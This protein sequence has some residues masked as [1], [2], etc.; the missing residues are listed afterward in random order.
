[1]YLAARGREAAVVTNS[2]GERIIAGDALLESCVSTRFETAGLYRRSVCSA[3]ADAQ[4]CAVS[5][6]TSV[7]KFREIFW[8]EKKTVKHVVK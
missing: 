2:F 5:A 1:M 3:A 6:A 8:F 7:V 4:R